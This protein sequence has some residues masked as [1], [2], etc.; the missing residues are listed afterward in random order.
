[1]KFTGLFILL[2]ILFS[3]ASISAQRD[4]AKAFGFAIYANYY[5]PGHATANFYNGKDNNRLTNLLNNPQIRDRIEEALGGYE[6]SLQEYANDMRYNNAFAFALELDYRFGNN[7][8][9]SV[10]FINAQVEAVGNFTLLVNRVNRNNQTNDPYLEKA[11]IAGTETR[12]HIILGLGKIFTLSDGFIASTEAGYN[13]NFVEATSNKII[14]AERDFSL[15][16]YNNQ[17][18]PQAQQITTFGS[19]FYLGAGVGYEMPNGYGFSF[20][21]SYINT[22]I[23]VNDVLAANSNIYVLGIGLSKAW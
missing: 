12:S 20:K 19:G 5:L 23:N 17:L 16:L 15:P 14:V 7:W 21:A 9:A 8:K 6:F 1:M 3:T 22:E 4:T 18:N 11:T 2:S 13:M 10:Q